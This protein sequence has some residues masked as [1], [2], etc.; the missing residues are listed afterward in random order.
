MNTSAWRRVKQSRFLSFMRETK[1][2]LEKYASREERQRFRVVSLLPPRPSR[3]NVLF[4]RINRAFLL[5]PGEAIP[6]THQ[7]LWEAYQMAQAFLDLGFAVDVIDYTNNIFLPTKDYALFVDARWNMERIGP[8]LNK[9][10][11]KMSHTVT[12]HPLFQDSAELGRLLDLQ[13]RRN[14]TLRP[15]RQDVLNWG[16]EHSD[17]ATVLGNEFTVGTYRYVNKPLYPIPCATPFLYPPPEGKDY[18][19]CRNRFLFM[20]GVGM[21]H[22]GLDRVLEAFASMPHLSL[23][24]CG[25][26]EKEQDF[27]RAYRKELYETKNIR[28]VGW[29]DVSS[30]TFPEL[31]NSCIALLHPSCSEG[32]A[33]SVVTCMHAGLIPIASRESGVDISREFG[34]VLKDSSIEEIREAVQSVG[35]LPAPRLREMAQASWRQARDVHSCDKF[36]ARYKEILTEVLESSRSVSMRTAEEAATR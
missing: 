2:Q 9:D 34:I 7:N 8:L 20:A 5:K 18:E 15:R 29:V 3:G 32:S 36:V 14:V 12:A 33:T 35:D 25:P 31:A 24:I 17:C 10:C 23:T 16:I 22:K 1:W 21:V 28:V 30:D 6:A 13:R 26:V 11:V 27:V 4:S 19:R